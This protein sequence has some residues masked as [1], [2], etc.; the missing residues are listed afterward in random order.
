MLSNLKEGGTFLLN[1][2][3]SDEQLAASM[4][5][6]M[7]KAMALKKIKFFVIDA[8]KIA[9]AIGMGRHTNTILQS[10]FFYLNPQ[11]MPYEEANSWMKK[12]AAKTYAKKGQDVV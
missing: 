5:T 1:T 2:N 8:N 11:I 9:L 4:P 7:K 10:A 3:M 6:R 12:F